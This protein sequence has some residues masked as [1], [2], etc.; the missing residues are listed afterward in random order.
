[1]L[2]VDDESHALTTT[3]TSLLAIVHTISRVTY[4]HIIHCISSQKPTLYSALNIEVDLLH[5]HYKTV[6]LNPKY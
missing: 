2:L 6:I 4:A 1:V 3:L 5:I